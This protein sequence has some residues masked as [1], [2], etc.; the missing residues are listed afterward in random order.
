VTMIAIGVLFVSGQMFRLAIYGQRLM[1]G[2]PGIS[3]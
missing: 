2:F 3:G 1:S